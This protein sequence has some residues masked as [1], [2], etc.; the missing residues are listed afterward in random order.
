MKRSGF[1]KRIGKPMR[2]HQ[3]GSKIIDL[4]R[5]TW[6]IFSKYIRQRDR[7]CITCGS[8]NRLHAGHFWHGVLDFDEM[9]INAQCNHCNT[10]LNGNLAQY[11]I[12]LINKYGVDKFKDLE[13]RHWIAKRGE[14]RTNSQ[15]KEII[16]KYNNLLV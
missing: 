7:R 6:N 11:S 5:K 1:K 8:T 4:H 13:Q 2:Q 9:N 10:Y 12:Y 15:F 16:E 14:Y 3:I